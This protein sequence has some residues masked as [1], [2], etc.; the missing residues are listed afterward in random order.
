MKIAVAGGTGVVGGHV[1]EALRGVGH[2][3]VVVARSRGVDVVTGRGLDAALDG[4]QAVVDT[5]NIA[6]WRRRP[7]LDFFTTASRNLQVAGM[8]AGVGHLVVLSIV[9]VDKVPG[10]GYYDA[11]LHQERLALDG[12]I[13]ATVVRATQFHEFAGQVLG[14]TRK[15]PVAVVPRM[16]V[17]TVAATAVAGVLAGIAAG[18]A[19][20]RLATEVTGPE[21][22]ELPELARR[23]M[24]HRGERARVFAV[25]LPGAVGRAQAGGALLPG[26]DASIVGPTFDEW[27]ETVTPGRGHGA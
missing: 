22:A 5:T 24:R 6:T 27:L 26:A 12:S 11:K 19:L 20:G 4:V 10:L 9:G 25:R 23:L 18:P 16:R 15:G 1:V 8:R 14:R 3:A 17:Q 2:E 21:Q 13:P 7:A